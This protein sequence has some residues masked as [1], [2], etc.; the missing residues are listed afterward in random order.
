MEEHNILLNENEL[1][2][3]SNALIHRPYG[4]VAQLILNMNE[5]IIKNNKNPNNSESLYPS[6][7]K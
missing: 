5:Q 1:Q 4:E 3:I 6:N 2:I 7:T